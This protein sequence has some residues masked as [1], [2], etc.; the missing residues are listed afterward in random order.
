MYVPQVR[1]TWATIFWGPMAPPWDTPPPLGQNTAQGWGPPFRVSN[2]LVLQV[3]TL[4]SR[5]GDDDD[6][7][8]GDV[9]WQVLPAR[10]P[11]DYR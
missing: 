10:L 7:K 9:R 4:I 6:G 11:D 5:G 1:R 3:I 2:Y 8:E